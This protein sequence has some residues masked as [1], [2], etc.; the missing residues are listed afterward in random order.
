ML[1]A[2][3]Y[4][5][6]SWQAALAT[7]TASSTIIVNPSSGPGSTPDPQYLQVVASAQAKGVGLLGYV[8]TGYTSLPLADLEQQVT[9]YR[10]WYGITGVYLDDVSSG[11]AQLG[12]YQA[13]SEAVRTTDPGATVV[14]NPGTFPDRSYASLGDVIVDFEGTYNS[15]VNEHPPTWVD[16]Y[17]PAMFASQVSGVAQSQMAATLGLAEAHHSGYV[18]LTDETNTA[19][20][21]EQ[22]PTYWAAELGAIQTACQSAGSPVPYRLVAGDGGVFSF[23]DAG[24]FGSTGAVRLNRPIVGMAAT[25]SGNGYWLVASDGGVFSFG[26]AGFF[27]STG[28]VRLNRPIVGMAA[29]PSG[30]GYWLVASDGGVFSFG[31]AGF[32]GSTGAVR[33]NRP[34]VGMAATPSGNGYWLVASDGG[35]FS[36][37]DAG[38]FGSTGAVRLN[39]PIVGMAATPSGNGYWLVA[40]DGGVFSFGTP[41]SSAPPE[42]VR[43]NRPDRGHGRHPETATATGWWPPT[44]EGSSPSGTPGSRARPRRSPWPHRSSA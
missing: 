1:P 25:P 4:P 14:L 41:G 2:Y 13:A 35:V 5:G 24:F 6:P 8:D 44:E 34:I 12:Y 37:G 33:L 15:F 26:D 20:L 3:F 30:N 43:L 19:T 21:Y 27:G 36:F 9:D 42:A 10:S 23:G 40:S 31:D 32:F 29:T 38:F 16:S 39:R 18:Y 11:A 22:L 17:P 28:A 7:A